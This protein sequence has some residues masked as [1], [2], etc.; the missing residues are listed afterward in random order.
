MVRRYFIK[1]NSFALADNTYLF[2]SFIHLVCL[3]AAL[4]I[5]TNPL[6]VSFFSVIRCRHRSFDVNLYSM[7]TSKLRCRLSIRCRHRIFDVVLVFDVDI[8]ASM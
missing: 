2:T 4:S 5:K 1:N 8:E 3:H 6:K 7:S